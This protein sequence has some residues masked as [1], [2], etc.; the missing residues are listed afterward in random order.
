MTMRRTTLLLA[1]LLSLSGTVMAAPFSLHSDEFKNGQPLPFAI[2]GGGQCPGQNTSPQLSWKDAP[3]ETKSFVLLIEDPQ[4][5]NGLGVTHFIGYGIDS[6]THQF[7]K[8][9]LTQG[10]G[11]IPGTNTKN[12]QGYSGPCPPVTGDIHN[13][14]F[15]LIATDLAPAALEKGLTKDALMK[16]LAGHTLNSAGLVG[17]YIFPKK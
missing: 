15:T 4:G 6:T 17:Q 1:G 11:Y 8:N 5:A 14:N 13:Y 10:S 9:A 16:A 7:A 12:V 2:G 3:K